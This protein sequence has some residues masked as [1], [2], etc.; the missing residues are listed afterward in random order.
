MKPRLVTRIIAS[1]LA[2]VGIYW[3]M[4]LILT[5]FV[6]PIGIVFN[7]LYLPGWLSFIGWCQVVGAHQMRVKRQT[8]WL[9]SGFSHIY[10]ALITHANDH[11]QPLGEGWLTAV[12]WCL[13]VSMISFVCAW[14][15]RNEKKANKPLVASGD[16][17]LL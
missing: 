12:H 11:F 13:F 7:L 6:P 16:N 3:C 10:L 15:E 8:F 17:A 2:L 14:L 9:F 5:L 4:M 1:L